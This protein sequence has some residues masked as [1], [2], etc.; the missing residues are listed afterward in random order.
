MAISAIGRAALVS[1]EAVKTEAYRDSVGIW[2]IGI[3]HTSAAG[4][5]H[6]TAGLS[7][8]VDEAYAIFERDLVKYEAT[9]DK[10]ITQP[11]TDN[12]RDAFVSIC[13]NI[14]QGGFAK[15]TFAKKF[16]AGDKE[17]CAA[18]I[19]SWRKPP[20]VF[21]RRKGEH[22]QFLTPYAVALPKARS[23]DNHPVVVRGG[24]ASSTG[25]A[26][27]AT[28]AATPARQPVARWVEPKL[29]TYE[30]EA[31]QK[32]LRELGYFM[33][34]K[35]DGKI[36][37]AFRGALMALQSTAGITQDGKFGPQT[38]V[39][40]ANDDNKRVI[41]EERKK[42][43]AEDLVAQGSKTVIAAKNVTFTSA[44]T[45]L[46]SMVSLVVYV[47]QNYQTTREAFPAVFEFAFNFVPGWVPLVVA[48][49]YTGYT[50]LSAKGIIKARVD[51]ERSGLHNGEPDPA[52]SPPL[53][54]GADTQAGARRPVPW[55]FNMIPGM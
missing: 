21:T 41:S 52:P 17:G 31:I 51:A 15:S 5:P 26:T 47:A 11:M 37:P 55:P 4:P 13:Y 2:T 30:V 10:V 36:G 45:F 43:T 44:F 14:G 1:R 49:L 32:R 33:V 35:V 12:E 20:E 46:G 38:K 3:G 29:E 28:G 48:A 34:G 50:W 53:T 8:S 9:V 54:Q 42:T 27:G 18:A 7:I 39:A 23:N 25:A 22:D 6:V 24:P 16:N 40:L 19:L